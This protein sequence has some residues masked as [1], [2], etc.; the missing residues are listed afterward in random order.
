MDADPVQV[1]VMENE[2]AVSERGGAGRESRNGGMGRR[3][4]RDEFAHF[5]E[6]GRWRVRDFAGLPCAVAA[7]EGELDA[8]R[9]S[10]GIEDVVPLGLRGL[11]EGFGDFS[12]EGGKA[13]ADFSL[14]EGA[15]DW[16]EFGEEREGGDGPEEENVEEKPAEDLEAEREGEKEGWAKL[17]TPRAFG[18]RE[19]RGHREQ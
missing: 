3:W 1:F 8:I 16:A 11:G 13:V 9:F 4:A 15:E 2:V 14:H 17:G 7:E 18:C 6:D 5:G 12:G 10:E 19:I